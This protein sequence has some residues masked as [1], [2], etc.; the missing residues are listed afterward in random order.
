VGGDNVANDSATLHEFRLF[1]PG[2]PRE[3]KTPMGV[4]DD[5]S[6][7]RGVMRY[8]ATWGGAYVPSM[9]MIPVLREDRPGRGGDQESFNDVGI[10]AVRF[11][12][13]VESP[14][15]GTVAS[16]QH[17]PNDLPKYVTPAY[18]ARVAEVVV[19]V[20]ASLAKAPP[21]PSM[22]QATG[23]AA[24]P[25]TVTWSG[26]VTGPAV[27]HYVVAARA[28]T[29]N[30]YRLRLTVP[31]SARSRVLTRSDVGLFFGAPFFLSVAA[32]DS[33]GHESLFAYPEYRC[34]AMGC[35]VQPGSLDVTAR[36]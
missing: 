5:T 30:F 7:A 19:A 27:D 26:P 22:L 32:V 31:A 3:L 11:I 21:P 17:S 2:T 24:G 25:W 36:K 20:A 13:A 16:H 33:A 4:T 12:E 14:D 28:A 18:T 15:A 34:D 10:P 8:V 29:D 1:S 35:I 6:P 9:T 23:A